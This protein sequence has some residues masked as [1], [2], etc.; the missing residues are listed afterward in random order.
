MIATD[1]PKAWLYA[2]PYIEK[3]MEGSLGETAEDLHKD[4]L[5]DRAQL[6]IADNGAA[7]SRV[8][9]AKKRVLH[10]VA[11]GGEDVDDWI[12][13]LM[14]EWKGFARKNG[15]DFIIAIGR[16][17]WKKFFPKLG[18]KVRKITGVWEAKDA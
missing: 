17:G 2:K 8:L 16:P 13:S 18:L 11:L 14:D 15:C 1:I 6:W 9:E 4:L 12:V 10:I 3:A 5:A 7:V